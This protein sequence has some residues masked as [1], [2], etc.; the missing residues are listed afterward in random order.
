MDAGIAVVVA[1][2]ALAAALLA[3]GLVMGGLRGLNA[4]LGESD[5]RVVRA[6]DAIHDSVMTV[7][8]A[9]QSSLM[10]VSQN[11]GELRKSNDGLLLET[12]RLG[13]L[14]DAFRLPGPRGGIGE[15]LLENI[16]RDLLPAGQYDLQHSFNDGSRVDAI[17]R[18]GDK[19]VPIDSKFPMAEFGTLVEASSDEDRRSARRGFLRAVRNHVNAVSAYVKP[20]EDTVDFALMYIPAENVFHQ[21]ILRERGEDAD[22][23]VPEYARQRNVLA[24]SPNTLFAY[25]QTVAMALRGM[26]IESHAREIAARIAGLTTDVTEL[27]RDLGVLGGHLTNVGRKFED[28]ERAVEGVGR[29]LT[30]SED[31]LDGD[32]PE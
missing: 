12:Q 1:V 16:L 11:L 20:D 22:S 6:I 29:K 25:L 32:D 18:V 10:Q 30:I 21:L 31:L 3:A 15:L 26:A 5:E 8:G 19:L 24:A 27:Q 2:V 17:V 13:E 28:V 4:R 9:S 14:R 7:S 23:A